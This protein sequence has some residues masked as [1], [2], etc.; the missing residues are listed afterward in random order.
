[1]GFIPIEK[2]IEIDLFGQENRNRSFGQENKNA[3]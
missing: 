3:L 1:V 2:R